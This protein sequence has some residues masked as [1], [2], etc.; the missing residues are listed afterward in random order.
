M[1]ADYRFGSFLSGV[2]FSNLAAV[3]ND[4]ILVFT[5]TYPTISNKHK[6]ETDTNLQPEGF[7][8]NML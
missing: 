3:L 7:Q 4:Y 5:E 8:H 2:F 6:V 1:N